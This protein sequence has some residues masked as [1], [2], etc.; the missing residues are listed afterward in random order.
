MEI[1][2]RKFLTIAGAAFSVRSVDAAA[3]VRSGPQPAGI[4]RAA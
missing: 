1:D 4:D 3:D 2:R